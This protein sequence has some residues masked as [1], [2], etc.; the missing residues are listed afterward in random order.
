[1]RILLLST[2]LYLIVVAVVL[3]FRPGFMFR[4][5]GTWKEFG[6]ESSE[7]TSPFPFWLFCITWAIVSFFLS[8]ALVKTFSGGGGVVALVAGPTA[9]AV[10]S[11]EDL[12]QPLAPPLTKGKKKEKEPKPGYYKLNTA[13]TKKNGVPRYIYLG[14][15]ISD[16][17]STSSEAD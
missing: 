5:D 14:P 2:F 13:A 7:A 9:A 1:M 6:L 12:L 3:Y 4:A 11:Q 17:E 15:E 8:S 16:D 10:A